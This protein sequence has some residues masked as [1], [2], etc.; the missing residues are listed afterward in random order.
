MLK[1]ERDEPHPRVRL[2]LLIASGMLALGVG[3]VAV[4]PRTA[5]TLIAAGGYYYVAVLFAL[6]GAYAWR[7]SLVRRE[8]WM[9]WLRAPA[10]GPTAL[11]LL[12]ATAFA[13]WSDPFQHK[14]LFDEYVL[15]ATALHMHATK[16][17][18]TVIRAYDLFGTWV[19]I[20]T[21][22]DK[23]PYF[24]TFLLSLVHDVTGYRMANVFFLNSAFTAMLLGLAYWFAR[25]LGLSRLSGWLVVALLVTMPLFGQNATGAGMEIH[26]LLMLLV[27][28][29]CGLLYLRA[30]DADRLSLFC[31]S[32]VLLAQSRYESVIFVGPV[33][34]VIVLGWMRVRHVILPWAAIVAP[35]LLVPYAWHNRVVSATPLLW[36]LH[37]GQKSRF[38]FDY[39]ADNLRGAVGFFFNVGPA[40]ANS[41]YLSVLGFVGLAWA[42]WRGAQWLRLR[43]ETLPA[44]IV[45]L[46]LFGLGVATNLAMLMF[47]YWARLDDSIASRFALPTCLMLALVA[48]L[49]VARLERPGRAATRW[50]MIGVGAFLLVSALPAMAHRLYTS[51]NLVMQEVDWEHDIVAA[52]DD[53]QVLFISNKS[54]I[55]WVL[56]EIPSIINGV[57][58]LRP[59]QIRWHMEQ[60][61]F[62]EVI[63]A[64]ALRPTTPDGK[65]GIDPDDVMPAGYHLQTIAE[66]R[67]GGRMA[68][69]SRLVSIDPDVDS[70]KETP[71]GRKVVH[72]ETMEER[73]RTRTES[74]CG[75]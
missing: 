75:F 6:F 53:R 60:H 42:V 44:S 12:V 1:V 10:S 58:R 29:C 68:R 66:K 72:T 27:T 38:S 39:L 43:R 73:G 46:T 7:V 49:F 2:L 8:A 13:L 34:V 21:F 11:A 9:S 35:L 57:A 15:Q 59:S 25:Q 74:D 28:M 45:V 64:Q 52:R 48:A 40:I 50:A 69:L 26:N 18:G 37:E 16:E 3:F 47:Y 19:P 5:E 32:T 65:F 14:V 22:L 56:W 51:Q 24:F 17:V 20:D 36:Q 41:W 71:A 54:T 61:T 63:V 33:A 30:P 4:T 62:K 55:P 31:L 23:R 67:F 70:P